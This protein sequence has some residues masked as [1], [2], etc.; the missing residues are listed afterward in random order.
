MDRV[1]AP[2]RSLCRI[3]VAAA[4]SNDFAGRKKTGQEAGLRSLC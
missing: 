2:V 1:A 3:P 4:A